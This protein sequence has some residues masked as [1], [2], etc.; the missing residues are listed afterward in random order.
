MCIRDRPSVRDYYRLEEIWGGKP[1]KMKIG[2][3]APRGL[4]KASEGLTSLEEVM[5]CLPLVLKPRP[6]EETRRLLGV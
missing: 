5:R 3:D 1:V 2:G 4:V 6:L